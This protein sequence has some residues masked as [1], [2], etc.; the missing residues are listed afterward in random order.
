MTHKA[1]PTAEPTLY[2]I[3]GDCSQCKGKTKKGSRGTQICQS[4]NCVERMTGTTPEH[5]N[6]PHPLKARTTSK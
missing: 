6:P 4:C 2:L 5:P 3:P 1:T